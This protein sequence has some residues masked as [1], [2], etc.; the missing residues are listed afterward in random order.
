MTQLHSQTPM[1]TPP[2]VSANGQDN[3]KRARS[4]HQGVA[5]RLDRVGRAAARRRWWVIGAWLVLAL[6]LGA[7]AQVA[8]GATQDTYR[9]PGAE[10]QRATDLLAERFPSYAGDIA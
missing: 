4:R 2:R 3:D 1:G 10:A 6:A 7:A 8:S 5:A 9:V